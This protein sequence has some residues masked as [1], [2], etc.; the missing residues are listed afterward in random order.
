MGHWILFFI[1][2]FHLY[3]FDSFGFT[4]EDY[5]WDI[6]DFF[7]SYPTCKTIVF[8]DPIQN[9]FSYVCGAYTILFSYLMCKN[10]SLGYIKSLFTRYRRKND[11]YAVSYLYSLVGIN[12]TCNPKYCPN[13]MYFGK[14]RAYCTC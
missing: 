4:P 7:G 5:G 6:T 1:K 14:C 10:Y 2:D 8:V 13:H 3:Y 12:L 9:E 11:S